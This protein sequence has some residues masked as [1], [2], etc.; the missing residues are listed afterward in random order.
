ML[1]YLFILF[2]FLLTWFAFGWFGFTGIICLLFIYIVLVFTD[3]IPPKRAVGIKKI[4]EALYVETLVWIIKQSKSGSILII[5]MSQ[6]FTLIS[7]IKFLL[8]SR[9]VTLTDPTHHSTLCSVLL[10][11]MVLQMHLELATFLFFQHNCS[12]LKCVIKYKS[13][14]GKIM[15]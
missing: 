1:F 14:R 12:R 5:T 13:I 6:F 3:S 8:L 10:K 7:G 15:M 9:Q 11:A 2:W 4:R